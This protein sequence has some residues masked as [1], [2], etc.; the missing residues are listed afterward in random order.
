MVEVC[1]PCPCREDKKEDRDGN[2]HAQRKRP[3]P[4]PSKRDSRDSVKSAERQHEHNWQISDDKKFHRQKT[5]TFRKTLVDRYAW[6]RHPPGDTASIAAADVVAALQLTL[7]LLRTSRGHSG[8]CALSVELDEG[9][10]G[11]PV[12]VTA[13]IEQKRVVACEPGTDPQADAWVAGSTAAWLDAVIERDTGQLETGGDKRL[14][15]A[16]LKGLHK[17][18]F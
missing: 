12:S 15:G 18:L 8:A 5:T 11:S 10:L 2:E 9:V 4:H 17:R 3:D 7:P 13:R 1:R 6:L 16:L 14:A